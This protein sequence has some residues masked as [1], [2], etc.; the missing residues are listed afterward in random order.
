MKII[1]HFQFSRIKD[2]G[3][4]NPSK[5]MEGRILLG[6]SAPHSVGVQLKIVLCSRSAQF[7]IDVHTTSG[8]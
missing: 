5:V 6:I 2:E 4:A 8:Y 7:S 1:V 3:G